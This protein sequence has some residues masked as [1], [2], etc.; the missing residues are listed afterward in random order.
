[1][2]GWAASPGTATCCNQH[3]GENP[4]AD[5]DGSDL[6]IAILVAR[7]HDDIARRLLR[8]AQEALERRG[9]QEPDL[10]WVPT[11]LDLPVTALA[12]AQKGGPA[13]ATTNPSVAAGV[14]NR[15]ADP[16][17][18]EYVTLPFAGSSAYSVPEPGSIAHTAPALTMGD[19]SAGRPTRQA[20][21]SDDEETATA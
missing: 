15:R 8:G 11:P 17:C 20:T 14:L 6:H 3:V 5:Q 10:F 12:L 9:V 13:G 16:R 2:Q 18:V 1:M 19:A 7:S 21:S 4:D